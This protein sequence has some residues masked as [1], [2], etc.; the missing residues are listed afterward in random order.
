MKRLNTWKRF[1]IF[2]LV[3]LLLS[4]VVSCATVS[5]DN[6]ASDNRQE[7][8]FWTMQLQPQFTDYFNQLIANFEA[9]NPELKIRWVDVPWSAME[10]RILASVSAKTAPD[11]VNLNPDFAA[12][13]AG[14]NAWLNLNEQVPEEVRSQY[15]PNILKANSI[16]RCKENN[17]RL[18]NYGVPW[19]LTTQITI[20]NQE[21]FQK[22]GLKTAPTTYTELAEF[23]QTIKEKTGKYALFVSFVPEDSS[24]VLQSLVQMGVQLVD[25]QRKA[26]FNSPEGKAAFQY[27]VDLYQNNLLPQE[28]LTQGHRRAIELYQAGEIAI[29]ISGPQ[30]FKAIAENAP[31]I[32]KV[33]TPA[34]QITGETGKKSVAVMNLVIPRETPNPENALK[35]ALFVTNS[36]NQLAFAKVANVLPSTVEAL[37]DSHFRPVQGRNTQE[38]QARIISAKQIDETDPLL[39][40]LKDI[41]RLQKIIYDNLQAAMLNE[42][43]VEQAL[44]DAE[45]A[46]NQR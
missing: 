3:G 31:T 13:L 34:P 36:T 9:A 38:D 33:S 22:A 10:S 1:G 12:L 20:Y 40:P 46:W 37:K 5:S 7:V 21:L 41:K 35:F 32:A 42:K 14:R 8:E 4:F 30:F 25:E 19:Y 11:V 15:L 45:N 18:E 6:N 23:A 28:V 29:L 44:L 39:P 26:A 2:A 27:W 16:E 17:C 24:Q 43:T